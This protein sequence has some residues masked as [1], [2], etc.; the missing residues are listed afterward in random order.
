MRRKYLLNQ[1]FFKKYLNG[2]AI[3]VIDGGARG[4]IF[5]PFNKVDNSILQMTRFDP[6][7]DAV[8][9]GKSDVLIRKALWSTEEEIILYLARNPSTS[10]VFPPNKKILEQFPDSRGNY[11]RETVK[12]IPLE[13]VSIDNLVLK[14]RIS[15]PD[16]IKLDIHGA[17]Y[18]ALVGAIKSLES[19]VIGVLVETW[20][21]PIHRGQKTHAK[22]ESLLD[23]LGFYLFD[24]KLIGNWLRRDETNGI[25]SKAQVVV[26]DNLYFK[27][28]VS[29]MSELQLYK[30]IGILNL[31]NQNHFLKQIMDK[32]GLFSQDEYYVNN[33]IK[34]SYPFQMYFFKKM[35]DMIKKLSNVYN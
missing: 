34:Q 35:R 28:D 13:G 9:T 11:A 33:L 16:F 15:P 22:V 3:K 8:I 12:E 18:E 6:D 27:M 17:E 10:S 14:G 5:E 25:Y 7:P 29:S 1:S 26:S 23:D 19:S 2:T 31:F 30:F 4:D 32:Y 24:S 21:L 20:T